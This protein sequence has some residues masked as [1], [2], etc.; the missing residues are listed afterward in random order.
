ME[1]VNEDNTTARFWGHYFHDEKEASE[2]YHA[3]RVALAATV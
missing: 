2:D 1:A 3:R